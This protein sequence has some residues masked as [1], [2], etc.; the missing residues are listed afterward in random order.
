MMLSPIGCDASHCC[1]CF[2]LQQFDWYCISKK[3]A[4]YVA[5]Q[6]LSP[7]SDKLNS[8]TDLLRVKYNYMQLSLLNRAEVDFMLYCTPTLNPIWRKSVEK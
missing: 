5:Q 1:S 2:G 7:V 8:I 3:L 6:S 4:W